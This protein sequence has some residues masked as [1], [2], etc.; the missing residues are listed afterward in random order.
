MYTQFKKWYPY[1]GP[2]DPCP[3]IRCK[4]Y[5]TPPQLYMTFQPPG[6]P[7]FSPYEALRTG[8]LWPA[9]YGPYTPN[10]TVGGPA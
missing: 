4:W 5:N 6:L 1:I 8:T 9:L 3:P 10:L 7:Q 2:F